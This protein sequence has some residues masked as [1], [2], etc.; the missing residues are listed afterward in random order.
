MSAYWI[1]FSSPLISPDASDSFTCISLIEPSFS[2]SNSYRSFNLWHS[3]EKQQQCYS[4]KTWNNAKWNK[5]LTFLSS[6]GLTWNQS[7]R[8]KP[9]I[10]LSFHCFDLA[11]ISP[12][13]PPVMVPDFVSRIPALVTTDSIQ[14]NILIKNQFD[15]LE[16]VKNG[17]D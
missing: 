1:F 3:T 15:D 16:Q 11:S 12:L 13:L 4:Q 14:I 6:H 8:N 17:K 5:L 9:S 7:K 2:K 10:F